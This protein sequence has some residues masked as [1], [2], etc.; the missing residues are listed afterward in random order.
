MKLRELREQ[1]RAPK[2]DLDDL[3]DD[4][5]GRTYVGVD[6]GQGASSSVLSY[7]CPK[8]GL[9]VMLNPPPDKVIFVPSCP[10]CDACAVCD[11]FYDSHHNPLLLTECVAIGI[12]DGGLTKTEAKVCDECLNSDRMRELGFVTKRRP[13]T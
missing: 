5:P 7:N 4:S 3:E 6:L 1:Y 2:D 12:T 9:L 13:R 11:K 8:C 10:K